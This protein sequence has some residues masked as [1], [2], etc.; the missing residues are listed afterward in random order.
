MR[1]IGRTIFITLNPWHQGLGSGFHSCW[2]FYARRT[3]F[4]VYFPPKSRRFEVPGWYSVSRSVCNLL[5]P[6]TDR[7][8]RKKKR[9]APGPRNPPSLMQ[10]CPSSLISSLL[11]VFSTGVVRIPQARIFTPLH[12]WCWADCAYCSTVVAR[13]RFMCRMLKGF[14]SVFLAESQRSPPKGYPR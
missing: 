14:P 5:V 3:S 2:I 1:G 6:G 13:F 4:L 8:S 11:W 7:A 12:S 10:S 9:R